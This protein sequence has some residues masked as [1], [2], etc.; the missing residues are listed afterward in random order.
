[1]TKRL[2]AEIAKNHIDLQTGLMGRKH[3][4]KDS[5]MLFDFGSSRPMAFWMKNTY[6]P[7]QVAFIDSKGV[8]G[9]IESM[10]PMSTK[11]IRSFSSYRYALEVNDGWFEE[12]GI[13]VGATVAVPGMEVGGQEGA[14]APAPD[15]QIDLANEQIL[16]EIVGFKVKVLV[17]FRTKTGVDVPPTEMEF[18]GEI[19]VDGDGKIGNLLTAWDVKHGR[20]TS[21]RIDNINQISDVDG[22]P[23]KTAEDVG[24]VLG[25]ERLD[26]EDV[27]SIRG[28][29]F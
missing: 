10:V 19:G 29:G 23:V 5:S 20:P 13:K 24:R 28:K 27:F 8:I 22:V 15:V 14:P 9:Q 4:S 16:K 1:M 6:I 11:A 3:L 26:Q 2:K 25:K 7:L 18:P 17:S 21:V 12:N